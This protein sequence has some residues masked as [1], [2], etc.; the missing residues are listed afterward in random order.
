MKQKDT[1]EKAIVPKLRESEAKM[2]YQTGLIWDG[3]HEK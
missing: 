2:L 1:G 3:R